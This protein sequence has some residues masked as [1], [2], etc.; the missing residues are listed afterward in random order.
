MGLPTRNI[1]HSG[2]SRYALRCV[3]LLVFLAL[4]AVIVI[5]NLDVIIMQT[6]TV[7]HHDTET[8]IIEEKTVRLRL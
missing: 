8:K 7:E 4:I 5:F 1:S 3:H 2:R 6:R